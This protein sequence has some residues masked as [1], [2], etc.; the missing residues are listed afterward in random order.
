LPRPAS[1]SGRTGAP[2]SAQGRPADR[3]P[4]MSSIRQSELDRE[5]LELIQIV[6]SE[7]T[8]LT[9]LIPPVAVDRL[10]DASLR[11]ILQACYDL[12]RDGLSPSYDNLMV[13]LDDPAIRE[14]VAS[15]IA[16]MAL[17]TPD[18]GPVT[19]RV[20][21]APWKERLENTLIVLKERERQKR[22][23]NLKR[24]LEETDQHAD[25]DAYNAIRLEYLR[26]LLQRDPGQK[27]RPTRIV[28]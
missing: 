15:L 14:L 17:S 20:Q 27:G 28:P 13:R 9:L 6:L 2:V 4:P 21:L 25:P 11:T 22:L 7:P 10:K 26:E 19:S 23:R 3:A 1:D 16:P 12:Q 5:D 24:S 18:P 8:A